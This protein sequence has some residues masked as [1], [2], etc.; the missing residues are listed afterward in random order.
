[1]A[2][3]AGGAAEGGAGVVVSG[4]EREWEEGKW[5]TLP[6]EIV[7]HVDDYEG[8]FGGVDCYG[9]RSRLDR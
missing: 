9:R 8:G 2:C 5:G 1:M 6:E 4:D 7:L 3:A